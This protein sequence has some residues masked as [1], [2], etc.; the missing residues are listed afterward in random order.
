MKLN[1]VGIQTYQ[2]VNR[3][4]N[5]ISHAATDKAADSRRQ[6]VTIT[7]QEETAASSIAVKGPRGLY[8]EFLSLEENQALELLFNRFRDTGRFG[9]GYMRDDNAVVANQNVGKM[10]D[11]KA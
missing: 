4:E 7:P 10:I 9:P 1:P 5:E 2:H 3:R 8:T 6:Q 11:V